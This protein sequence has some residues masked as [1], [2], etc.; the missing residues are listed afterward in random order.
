MSSP[1]RILLWGG[2]SKA[3]ILHAMIEELYQ[4]APVLIHDHTL[5]EPVFATTAAFSSDVEG[6]RDRVAREDITHAVVA[7]GNAYG[8]ARCETAKALEAKL[9]LTPLDLVHPRSW[10]EP[11][12]ETGPGLQVMPQATV[13]RFCRIGA[14]AILNTN[15]TIDHECVLGD[16]VHVMGS[17]ALAG[18]VRVGDHATIGTNATILP[19]VRIG[20]GAYVGA[21]AVVTR[22]V[23]E[24]TVVAGVPA[25]PLRQVAPAFDPATV[26]FA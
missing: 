22:D 13:H 21:G 20:A 17:A 8:W 16:G 18:R 5:D 24:N 1:P 25:K 2:R 14:H 26:A 10:I 11:D 12:A 19:D 6:L 7:I 9:G 3:R 23:P 4:T 15:C